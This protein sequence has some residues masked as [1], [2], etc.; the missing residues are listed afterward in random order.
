MN[1]LTIFRYCF[2]TPVWVCLLVVCSCTDSFSQYRSTVSGYVFGPGRSPIGQVA[3]EL[4]NDVNST[5]GRTK[6]DSSGRFMFTGVPSGRLSVTVLP[7]GT[8]FEGQTRE[9]EISGVGLR[10]QLIPDN[11]QVDFYLKLKKGVEVSGG[12]EV[13]FVQ[14]VPE[15]ARRIYKSAISDLDSQ[16]VEQGIAELKQAVALFPTYF[17]ALERLGAEQLKQKRWEEAAKN[18]AVCVSVNQ[19]SFVSWYGLTYAN[20]ALRKWQ[21]VL[22][23]SEKALE[24]E[25][26]SVNTLVLLGI[27]QRNL[28]RFSEAEKSLIRAK[29]LD[30]GKTPDL[31]WNLAL[32]Y[33][34]NLKKYQEA[35]DAL[36]LY[37]KANPAI[38]DDTNVRKLIKQLRENRPPG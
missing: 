1:L 27:T 13:V 9:I 28:Q 25:K 31:Y 29:K 11:S 2:R 19:R 6:T 8:N 4:R 30:E 10:G 34:Y 23:S 33:A 37:L 14:E 36:E 3:V 38:P 35:A 15:E 26:N 18:F 22:A 32:L 21:D 5:I 16:R 20:F 7:L 24:L 17:V 12:S